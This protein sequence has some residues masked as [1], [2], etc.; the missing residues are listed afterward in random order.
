MFD[1]DGD[2]DNDDKVNHPGRWRAVAFCVFRLTT[3]ARAASQSHCVALRFGSHG[4]S[5]FRIQHLAS[6]PRC[7]CHR[8]VCFQQL[9][10]IL[11]ALK[12]FLCIFWKMPKHWQDQYIVQ[13]LKRG[14]QTTTWFL[15]GTR[16]SFK[17]IVAILGLGN[18]RVERAKSGRPDMRFKV[19][20]CVPLVVEFKFRTCLF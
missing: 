6:L 1:D 5:S 9:T 2:D 14:E 8:Q 16:L 18:Q 20:G 3:L 17:C 4:A 19:W 12:E 11:G 13:I 10:P 15:L 7:R